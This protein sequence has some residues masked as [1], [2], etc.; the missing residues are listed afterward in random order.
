[1]AK[2]RDIML[3]TKGGRWGRTP[4][5]PMQPPSWPAGRSR[6]RLLLLVVAAS[7][8]CP[9]GTHAQPVPELPENPSFLLDLYR[10]AFESIG[11]GRD[12]VLHVF[13][14]GQ[15][16]D[17]LAEQR[18]PCEMAS[19]PDLGVSDLDLL[20]VNVRV[21]RRY[22]DVS[23]SLL[24]TRG[25]PD[26]LAMVAWLGEVGCGDPAMERLAE[27]FVR[28][29]IWLDRQGARSESET[30]RREPRR[31]T[32]RSEHF[33]EWYDSCFAERRTIDRWADRYCTCVVRA[34]DRH[35]GLISEEAKSGLVTDFYTTLG[36]LRAERN[37]LG[38]SLF[39]CGH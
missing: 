30:P 15:A 24:A 10:G 4:P 8:L 3:P 17:D 11:T 38:R 32:G 18:G 23:L 12:G 20:A 33:D 6:S 36:E 16:F 1:M 14:F 7:F 9:K 39:R 13:M 29:M 2:S 26:Y 31:P 34:L 37:D 22:P 5:A 35:E 28:Y 21:A 25:H 19:P 27:N